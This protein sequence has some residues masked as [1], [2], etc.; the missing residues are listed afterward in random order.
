MLYLNQAYLSQSQISDPV[1]RPVILESKLCSFLRRLWSKEGTILFKECETRL[2]NIIWSVWWRFMIAVTAQ[3]AQP[4]FKSPASRLFTQPFIQAQIK[5]NIC[6]SVPCH[7]PLCGDFTMDWRIPRTKG[8]KRGKVSIWWRHHISVLF[9][10]LAHLPIV[11]HM[12]VRESNEYW[13]R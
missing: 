2:K 3:W 5:G 1:H 12:R 8:Q 7:W 13:C 6:A 4:R 9:C 11:P 10:N